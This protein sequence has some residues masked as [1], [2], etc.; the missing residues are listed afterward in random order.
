MD[1]SKEKSPCAV[2]SIID[3]MDTIEYAINRAEKL[4]SLCLVINKNGGST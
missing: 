3:L 2:P 1:C 4:S